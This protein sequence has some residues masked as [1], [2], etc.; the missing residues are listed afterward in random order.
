MIDWTN[1]NGESTWLR[2]AQDAT[3]K[4][5]TL[6]PQTQNNTTVKTATIVKRSTKD[7]KPQFELAEMVQNI[8]WPLHF[9]PQ[10]N[11]YG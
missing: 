6:F 1:N 3:A 11:H 8:K 9:K 7:N 10:K 5:Y 2:N 4:T